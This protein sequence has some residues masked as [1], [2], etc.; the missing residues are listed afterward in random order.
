MDIYFAENI[1]ID[2]LVMGRN[3]NFGPSGFNFT[4]G[5]PGRFQT[6]PKVIYE[7]NANKTITYN[8]GSTNSLARDAVIVRPG[9][10]GW[11]EPPPYRNPAVKYL[12]YDEDAAGNPVYGYRGDYPDWTTFP[13]PNLN[14]YPRWVPE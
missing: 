12:P 10:S 9:D 14:L 2:G 13:D 11:E 8:A 6:L 3:R 5:G 4:T 7:R 1:W